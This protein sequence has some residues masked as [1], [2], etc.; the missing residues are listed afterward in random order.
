MKQS[1]QVKFKHLFHLVKFYV[2]SQ[3]T[4]EHE[5]NSAR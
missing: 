5:S 4:I 3:I 1:K 2:F